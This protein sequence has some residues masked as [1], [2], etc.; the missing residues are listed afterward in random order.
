[1]TYLWVAL[2]G[3]AGAA[4]TREPGR[5]ADLVPN[6]AEVDTVLFVPGPELLADDAVRA[7]WESEK[8][9]PTF[10]P[11]V[12]IGYPETE[13]EAE[14]KSLGSARSQLPAEFDRALITFLGQAR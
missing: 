5:P 3:A 10:T 12:T 2:G 11:H 13:E 1:M 6:P 9:W 4:A 14:R 7:A 8:Q